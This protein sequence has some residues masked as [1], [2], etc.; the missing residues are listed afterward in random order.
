MI[1]IIIIANILGFINI[2]RALLAN[3][4]HSNALLHGV[5]S[6]WIE[7]LQRVQNTA[8]G[9]ITEQFWIQYKNAV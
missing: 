3:W 7:K 5:P 4:S 8:G 6:T 1:I 9:I 2:I